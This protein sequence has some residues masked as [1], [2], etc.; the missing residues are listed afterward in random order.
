MGRRTQT[1]ALEGK[2]LVFHI[3]KDGVAVVEFAAE[4]ALAI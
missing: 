4:D 1:A 2:T 3:H